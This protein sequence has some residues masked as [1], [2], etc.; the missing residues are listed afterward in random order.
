MQIS[1]NLEKRK[2]RV[3]CKIMITYKVSKGRI[4]S[5]GMMHRAGPMARTKRDS[6]YH[7]G[8]DWVIFH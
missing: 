3:T 1:C 4:P 2:T 6:P 7:L 8:W 5:F